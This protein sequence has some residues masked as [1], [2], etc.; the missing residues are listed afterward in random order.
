MKLELKKVTQPI[1]T[2]ENLPLCF[3]LPLGNAVVVTLAC[4]TLYSDHLY[5][6]LSAPRH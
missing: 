6:T 2:E 1:N 3:H 4:N 5:A